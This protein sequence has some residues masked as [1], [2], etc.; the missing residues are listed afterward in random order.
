[1]TEVTQHASSTF[2][3]LLVCPTIPTPIRP[4]AMAALNPVSAMAPTTA[5]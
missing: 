4:T 1:M 3:M 5:E 2:I